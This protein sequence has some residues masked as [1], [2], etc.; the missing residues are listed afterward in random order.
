[1]QTMRGAAQLG[2]WDMPVIIE[3]DTGQRVKLDRNLMLHNVVKDVNDKRGCG[4]LIE[5]PDNNT[6]SRR[7]WIDPDH[8]IAM[9]EDG[10]N[11]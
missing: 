7:I 4:K 5:F 11:Y 1:M 2:G 8:V 10:H 6:P 3:M 9:W